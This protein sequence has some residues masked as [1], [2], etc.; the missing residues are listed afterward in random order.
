MNKETFKNHKKLLQQEFKDKLDKF[1]T[2]CAYEIAI[3]Q[4]S[5]YVQNSFG[6]IKVDSISYI[7]TDDYLKPVYTGE[8]YIVKEGQP[9]K[10]NCEST[11]SLFDVKKV[12][13]SKPEEFNLGNV[14]NKLRYRDGG[15][16]TLI[17]DSGKI[18][19]YNNELLG[20]LKGYWFYG[21]VGNIY[22]RVN[23]V[24]DYDLIRLLEKH[25]NDKT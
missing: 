11:S 9:I 22:N 5:E 20:K 1:Y 16:T 10:M 8:S 18:Y 7:L 25:L 23:L 2:R 21:G 3:A 15:S 24:K 4:E 13:F 19:T 6:L 12:E 14:I 17:F